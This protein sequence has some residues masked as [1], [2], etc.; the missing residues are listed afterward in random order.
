MSW[1]NKVHNQMRRQQSVNAFAKQV[2]QELLHDKELC[3]TIKKRTIAKKE[4]IEN[5]N[6]AVCAEPFYSAC[7]VV[8]HRKY[9]FGEKRIL[10]MFRD[11]DELLGSGE[12][13]IAL[14]EE[15]TGVSVKVK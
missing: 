12:D 10:N 9:G 15:E 1:A 7:A 3:E 2:K 8:L 4:E 6:A 11:I 13:M 5:A 14:C